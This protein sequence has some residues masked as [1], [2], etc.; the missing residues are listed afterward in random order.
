LG[1][2]KKGGAENGL[3]SRR[4]EGLEGKKNSPSARSTKPVRFLS[5]NSKGKGLISVRR[6]RKNREI[7]GEGRKRIEE[8]LLVY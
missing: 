5:G 3:S 2:K 1:L 4:A 6:R 8:H 7:M